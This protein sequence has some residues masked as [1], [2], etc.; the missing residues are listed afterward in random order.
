MSKKQTCPTESDMFT[1][2]FVGLSVKH[3]T[4]NGM[5]CGME[6]GTDVSII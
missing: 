1:T 5:E 6:H 4:W 2:L 3:G